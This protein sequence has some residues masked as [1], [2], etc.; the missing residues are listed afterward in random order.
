[1]IK[2]ISCNIG[3]HKHIDLVSKYLKN[4]SSD[5]ITLQEIFISDARKLSELL[6]KKYI[7]EPLRNRRI[8]DDL[9]KEFEQ[10]GLATFTNLEI[11][12][13]KTHYYEGA[14]S[15]KIDYFEDG[16]IK[17]NKRA[18]LYTSIIKDSEKY[19][20]AH[21][22][23]TGWMPGTD[24]AKQIQHFNKMLF[25]LKENTDMVLCGDLNINRN[26]D[27]L[28]PQLLELYRDNLT[29]IDTTIDPKLHPLSKKV[30]LVVD[31]LLTSKHYGVEN[32][33]L[34]SGVSDHKAISATILKKL[35]KL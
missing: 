8:N 18:L 31:A 4:N 25:F 23:F 10:W 33:R 22:H 12:D 29:I 13:K 30:K 2:L 15:D 21:T 14:R 28:F 1:M 32:V 26:D 17:N 19:N 5:V 35:A 27:H 11:A 16:Q 7:F 9:D 34:I 3:G 20:I 6:D 24:R